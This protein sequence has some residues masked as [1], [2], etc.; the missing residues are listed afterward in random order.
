MKDDSGLRVGDCLILSA[1][2]D[3]QE[4]VQIVGFGSVYFARP[5]QHHHPAGATIIRFNPAERAGSQRISSNAG[6]TD[7][8]DG[9][10]SHDSWSSN[11]KEHQKTRYIRR[12]RE[13]R[14]PRGPAPEP[15]N[16][17][18]T[19]RQPEKFDCPPIPGFEKLND[20]E[21]KIVR[22]FRVVTCGGEHA[23][24]YILHAIE[25]ARKNRHKEKSDEWID[26][27]ESLGSRGGLKYYERYA[28]H[29]IN[30]PM[31]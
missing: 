26:T 19:I 22:Q 27:F 30:F 3:R 31:H 23:E 18:Q 4:I 10:E 21:D 17:T 25:A 20:W 12:N 29:W 13:R 28:R 9:Y 5:T 14:H 1:D 11:E 15:R 24:E 7:D 8:L 16:I 6:E 2:T